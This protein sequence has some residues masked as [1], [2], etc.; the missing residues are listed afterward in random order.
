MRTAEAFDKEAQRAERKRMECKSIRTGLPKKTIDRQRSRTA[1]RLKALFRTFRQRALLLSRRFLA[2]GSAWDAKAGARFCLAARD[3]RSAS[4]KFP[5]RDFGFSCAAAG[6]KRR[7]TFSF[8]C[9]AGGGGR[10][11]SIL[12]LTA[13]AQAIIIKAYLKRK[14]L[15]MM[16]VDFEGTTA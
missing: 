15:G 2:G 14:G 6:A 4:E 8:R 11:F 9:A 10:L 5:S 7:R 13:G 1:R 3:K 12:S 16:T